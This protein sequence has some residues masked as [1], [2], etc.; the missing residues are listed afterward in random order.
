MSASERTGEQSTPAIDVAGLSKHFGATLA[1]DGVDLRVERGQTFG[2]LG[3]N[4]AGKTTLVKVL[5]GLTRRSG[6]DGRILGRPLGHAAARARVGYLPELFRYPAWLTPR[7]VLGLHCE[8]AGIARERRTGEIDRV[9]RTVDLVSHGH[10]RVG[11]FS[12]GMQQ[13]LGLAVALLGDPELV[14]LD[15]PT[16]ALDPLGREDVRSIVR[17]AAERGSTV[18]LNSH[19]LGEVERSCERVA[20]LDRGRV[21][22]SG[23]PDGLLGEPIVRVRVTGLDDPVG[24]LAAFGRVMAD[25]EDLTVAGLAAD[26]VPDLVV[27]IVAAGGRIHAV[28]PLRSSLED[29]FLAI[30]R[31]RADQRDTPSR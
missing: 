29:A 17:E 6:G 12:K 14:I 15:E 31:D 16:S 23:P 1:L 28:E 26:R 4:G 21:V 2:L 20:I 7:E 11:A 5:L 9:L 27:A 8:L 30:L 25:G 13:R 19:L 24:R 18:V 10:R 3:P 22:A